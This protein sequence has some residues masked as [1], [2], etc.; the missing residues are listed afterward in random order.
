V[1]WIHADSASKTI[2]WQR[3]DGTGAPAVIP[4]RGLTPFF[5]QFDPDGKSIIAAVGSPFRHDIVRIPLDTSLAPRPLANTQADELQPSVSPDGRWLTFTNNELGRSEVFVASVDDPST[6]VQITNDGAAEPLWLHDS[7]TVVVRRGTEFEAITLSFTP[8][9][10]VTKRDT[11]VADIYRRGNPDRGYD[12]NLK[13]GELVT[14]A[15]ATATRDRI[16]V[17]TRWFDELRERLAQVG[18]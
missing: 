17:V 16:V 12:V 9:I 13:T 10:E 6:R 8:R 11:L 2:R 5:F 4:V 1:G 14:M 3:A 18:K 7:K 15:R